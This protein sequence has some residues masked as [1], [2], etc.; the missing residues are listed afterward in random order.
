MLRKFFAKNHRGAVYHKSAI[1]GEGIAYR[2][3]KV[4]KNVEK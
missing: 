3:H 4:W 2:K 1:Q